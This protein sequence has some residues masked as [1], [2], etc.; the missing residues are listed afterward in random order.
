LHSLHANFVSAFATLSFLSE[1]IF[2]LHTV[3]VFGF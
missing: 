2:I 3:Y 1:G